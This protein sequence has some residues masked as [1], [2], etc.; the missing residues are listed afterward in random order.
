MIITPPQSKSNPITSY[1]TKSTYTESEQSIFPPK[2][3]DSLVTILIS[4][5]YYHF[6]GGMM[7]VTSKIKNT[8]PISTNI[9]DAIKTGPAL[10]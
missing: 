6:C 1:S 8:K 10:N 3:Q 9:S 7:P 2:K 5:T 4:L